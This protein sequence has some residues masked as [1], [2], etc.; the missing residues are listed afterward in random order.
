[1]IVTLAAWLYIV[2]ALLGLG[3]LFSGPFGFGGGAGNF[4]TLLSS[5]VVGAMGYGLLKRESWGRWLA[6]GV[7]L[8]SWT[9][10]SL[11]LLGALFALLASGKTGEIFT[12]MFSNGALVIVAVVVLVFLLIMVASVVISFK[13]FFYL[14]SQEGCEEFNVPYGSAGTV[15]ASV[16]A[17]IAMLVGQL[18][19][20]SGGSGALALLAAQQLMARNHHEDS[21]SRDPEADRVEMERRDY[22]RQR[23]AQQR[24]AEQEARLRAVRENEEQQAVAASAAY[25]PPT[26]Q[27]PTQEPAVD[28][29]PVPTMSVSAREEKPDSTRILKCRD[30]SGA[31]TF[32]QGYCPP[33]TKRVDMP[34]NE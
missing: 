13:L 16:G 11:L 4:A 10:G 2:Q 8:L 17:W 22:L 5:G 14:C 23:E 9:F 12:T 7:S 30:A 19:M 15:V 24:R 29:A 28:E 18:F 25:V 33:G 1:V 6:L 32:T 31:V 20:A 21:R 34:Q 27:S 26:S 3:S